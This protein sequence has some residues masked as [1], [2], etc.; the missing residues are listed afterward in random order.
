MTSITMMLLE[1]PQTLLSPRIRLT[2]FLGVTD[3]DKS[4]TFDVFH[5]EH[6]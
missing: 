5:E 3:F 6:K 1:E 2:L 4:L